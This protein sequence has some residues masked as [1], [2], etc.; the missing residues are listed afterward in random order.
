MRRTIESYAHL[1]AEA[2]VIKSRELGN[3]SKA[4]KFLGGG[5]GIVE[6]A[7]IFCLSSSLV[8]TGIQ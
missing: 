6:N 5:N 7:T 3:T 1:R 2:Y 4:H 8:L